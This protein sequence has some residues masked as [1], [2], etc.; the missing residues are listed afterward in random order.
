L[1]IP[2]R[3]LPLTALRT[4]EA[5]ARHL[6]FKNAAEELFVSATTVSNQIR[7]L[8]KDWGCKLFH[9]QTRAVNLTDAGRSLA[10]V[11]TRA[12][13]DIQAEVDL[14][15]GVS[16]RTVTIA[17]G[18]IFG[19]RWLGPRLSKLTKE[20]PNIELVVHHGG[21]ITSAAQM[22][23]DIAVD[24]GMGDWKKLEAKKLMDVYYSPIVS[25]QIL[26]QG[27]MLS[28]PSDL[29]NWPIIHQHDRSEWRN[30]FAQA[31]CPNLQPKNEIVIMDSNMVQRAVKDGQG[32]ALGV[33]PLME[34]DVEKGQLIKPFAI[35]LPPNRA[36][37]LLTRNEA[38]ERK[39]LRIVCEWMEAQAR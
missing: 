10:K 1:T 24:W 39:E 17:V 7:Q 28:Q 23:T 16:R 34:G 25:P 26:G 19:S 15:S 36:F 30:W 8:E 31:G 37:Y 12:F 3:R 18:P 29:A 6:S 35:D 4:F 5:A 27:V 38:R 11:L 22:T 33:F 13:K 32:V 2:T 21:R 14:H 9:R 20:H